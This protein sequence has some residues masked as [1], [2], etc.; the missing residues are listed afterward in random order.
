MTSRAR[1]AR[2]APSPCVSRKNVS[3]KNSRKRRRHHRLLESTSSDQTAA[4]GGNP[5]QTQGQHRQQALED[6]PRRGEHE[7]ARHPGARAKGTPSGGQGIPGS[8]DTCLVC[9]FVPGQSDLRSITQRARRPVN[10]TTMRKAPAV[11]RKIPMVMVTQLPILSV[12]GFSPSRRSRA[13]GV[14]SP[15]SLL[16]CRSGY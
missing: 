4:L 5:Q 7:G 15:C 3:S 13:N 9:A 8:R 6:A 10:P 14:F 11:A 2:A 12:I 1:S 16:F